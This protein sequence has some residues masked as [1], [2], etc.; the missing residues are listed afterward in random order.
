MVG[1]TNLEDRMFQVINTSIRRKRRTRNTGRIDIL[2]IAL[3]T[4]FLIAS[5]T[6][7]ILKIVKQSEDHVDTVKKTKIIYS[8][9]LS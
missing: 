4:L 3:I 7:V 1:V 9:S 6:L 2:I 5:L 8:E